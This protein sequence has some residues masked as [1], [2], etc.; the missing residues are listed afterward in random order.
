MKPIDISDNDSV[1]CPDCE[2]DYLHHVR[3]LVF[4]RHEDSS[5]GKRVS[6]DVPDSYGD[7]VSPTVIVEGD[8]TGNPSSRRSGVT[9]V[10]RCEHCEGDKFLDITQHKGMTYM[11]WRK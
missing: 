9:L 5:E 3:V 10:F 1:M 8:L 7:A 11:G 6:V 4:S 2:E